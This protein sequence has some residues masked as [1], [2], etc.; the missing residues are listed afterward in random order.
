MTGQAEEGEGETPVAEEGEDS[1][2]G[3]HFSSH[4]VITS[5]R[6]VMVEPLCAFFVSDVKRWDILQ[7][8]VLR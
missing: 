7:I 3:T 2:T 1:S 6:E 8:F 4:K 5:F